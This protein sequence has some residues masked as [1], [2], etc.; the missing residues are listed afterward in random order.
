MILSPQALAC[1]A[2]GNHIG[3]TC[4]SLGEP[5]S[6][7]LQ[8]N[9]HRDRLSVLVST[10]LARGINASFIVWQYPHYGAR[11]G[12]PLPLGG[13]DLDAALRRQ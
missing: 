10:Y 5:S 3:C 12:L 11:K 1:H 9:G 7:S 13:H 6:S 8:L 4:N 2:S